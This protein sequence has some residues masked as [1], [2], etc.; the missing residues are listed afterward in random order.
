MEDKCRN[1]RFQG[2]IV[3]QWSATPPS[4]GKM[5]MNEQKN[6]WWSDLY[7][8]HDRKQNP[9]ATKRGNAP[10]QSWRSKSAVFRMYS[11]FAITRVIV[12]ASSY[13]FLT[14]GMYTSSYISV[15]VTKRLKNWKNYIL[16]Q[17]KSD[18]L[19]LFYLAFY[20]ARYRWIL[21]EL[22]FYFISWMTVI[23]NKFSVLYSKM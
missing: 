10:T 16:I 21:W 18:L 23:I 5:S 11:R 9:T 6:D 7:K 19:E 4:E 2:K 3:L 15:N 1:H 17:I 14:E 22:Y 13:L 12:L 20:I 8:V